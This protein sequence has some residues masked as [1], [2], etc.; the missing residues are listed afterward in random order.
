MKNFNKKI[1][2]LNIAGLNELKNTNVPL[3][4]YKMAHNQKKW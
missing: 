1:Y 3:D 2:S 4:Y